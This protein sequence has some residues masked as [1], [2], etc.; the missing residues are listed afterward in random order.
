MSNSANEVVLAV[1]AELEA[2]AKKKG[3]KSFLKGVLKR[4]RDS[5]ASE[6]LLGEISTLKRKQNGA[7]KTVLRTKGGS[8]AKQIAKTKRPSKAEARAGAT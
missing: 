5:G 2:Q 4:L 7:A 6:Q 8:K 1:L 3:K